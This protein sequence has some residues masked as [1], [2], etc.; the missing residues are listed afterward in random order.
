LD[1]G[2]AFAVGAKANTAAIAKNQIFQPRRIVPISNHWR[3]TREADGVTENK[4]RG[5]AA[6]PSPVTIG[7]KEE[8]V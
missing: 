1:G 7:R 4:P 6:T 8:K 3:F 2:D 5:S